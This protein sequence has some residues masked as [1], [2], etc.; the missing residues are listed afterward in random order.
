MLILKL[1]ELDYFYVSLY[2]IF[3]IIY[4]LIIMF[5]D[6]SILKYYIFDDCLDFLCLLR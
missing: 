6:F 2:I 1:L 4:L 5:D 3:F